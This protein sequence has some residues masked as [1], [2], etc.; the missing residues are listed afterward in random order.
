MKFFYGPIVGNAVRFKEFP[1]ISRAL[2]L[3]DEMLRHVERVDGVDSH[4]MLD[5]ADLV[6]VKAEFI[7]KI[8][9]LG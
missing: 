6:I 8:D 5:Y 2:P 7:F 3:L 1:N 9:R 4:G